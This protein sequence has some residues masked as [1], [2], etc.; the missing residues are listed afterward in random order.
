LPYLFGES[1][2]LLLYPAGHI[3]GSAMIHLQ[4]E[5]QSFLY[6]G[7]FKLRAGRSA[8]K[9]L[10][11]QADVVVMETTFGVPKYVFPP[12]E[13][14]LA[15]IVAF[16]REALE[17]CLVPVL[18]GYSLGKSQEIISGL[19]EAGLPIMLHPQTEKM[20]QIY[21]KLGV[22]FPAFT[23]FDL[24]N[25][26]GHVV[27]CPPQANQSAWLRKI[28][29]RRTAAV[30]G[31]AM[32]PGAIF[33]YQCDAAFPLS[34]HADFNDL[35]KFVELA[36]PKQVW[37]VHGFTDEFA[38]T[39]RERGIEAWPLG[40][41]SQLE[42]MFDFGG[43]KTTPKSPP[44]AAEEVDS[45][46]DLKENPQPEPLSPDD[47]LT[48]ALTAESVKELPGKL[49]KVKVL[50][51]Y[52]RS[53]SNDKALAAAALALT[54]RAFPTSSGRALN[55]G[56]AIVKRAVLAASGLSETDFR[57]LYLRYSDSGDSAA[58]ALENKTKPEP[59]PVCEL[60]PFFHQL[61]ELRGPLD[62]AEWL[63]ARL[64]RMDPLAAKYLVK[65]VTGWWKTPFPRRLAERWR[66]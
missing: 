12:T 32:D 9:C 29:K 38:R 66:R 44:A 49:A 55:C 47:V 50:A 57:A 13:L 51:E 6:T 24:E 39:L 19:A 23:S 10:V 36:Q 3:F 34:D 64:V 40:K 16:C 59:W 60:T 33:R 14:V 22:Q 48:W 21:V 46:T 18:F 63:R 17:E 8:E 4:R 62:K 42:L 11:P 2:E 5:G 25:V 37:T 53:L 28:K 7:D 65:V 45:N 43:T 58:A 1:T 54:G 30:T 61:A 31:W 56:W 41:D 27:I 26:A 35:L 15:R 20:T 52:F